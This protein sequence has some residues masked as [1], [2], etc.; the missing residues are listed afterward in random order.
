[1]HNP[2]YHRG[3]IRHAEDFYGRTAEVN[4]I[5]GLLRNGQSVSLIGPRRIG[6]SSLLLHISRET[7]RA[8]YKL[9]PDRVLVVVVDSQEL[10]GSPAGE[11][12][13]TLLNVI[14]DAAEESGVEVGQ[15]PDVGT[16]RALDRLLNRITKAGV[17]VIILLDEFELLAAND[18][19]TPYFFA[20]LRG[21]TTKYGIAYLTASQRPLFSITASEEILSSPFFNIFVSLSLG[22]FQDEEAAGLL[23]ERLQDYE[24][25]FTLEQSSYLLWLAGNHPFFLHIAGYHAVQLLAQDDNLDLG[26]LDKLI[27]METTSHLGYLWQNL[28][29]SE[30][31]SLA[32]A[33]GPVDVMRTLEQ[34]CLLKPVAG[35][36]DLDYTS[37]LLRR[38]VRRQEV[39]G[40]VQAAPFVVD[41]QRHKVLAEKVELDLTISQFDL[42]RC[43]AQQPG[44]VVAA[45]ELERAVWGE[46][47]LDD[48]DRLKTLIKRLRRAIEPYDN[49]I[50]S[51]RGVGY[52]LRRPD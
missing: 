36:E 8:A 25:N 45:G 28:N 44:L 50:V 51:E 40:L 10:A 9:P 16:Y 43:L 26:Q 23:Q 13:E 4:Q 32:V 27:E 33:A 38:F 39:P 18:Q 2:F 17:S 52:A 22:E 31:Y 24:I 7:V 49:W 41:E 20:R 30:R 35:S 48:P 6:K 34:Q 47:L 5:L 15:L 37:E 14:C 29:N 3:A 12:Y 46:A 42:F 19:L 1:M 21:L 11:V